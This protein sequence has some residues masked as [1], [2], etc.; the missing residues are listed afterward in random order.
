MITWKVCILN[1]EAAKAQEAVQQLGTWRDA[2]ALKRVMLC[3]S[4]KQY[5]I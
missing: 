3:A 2:A 5:A 1:L 4:A